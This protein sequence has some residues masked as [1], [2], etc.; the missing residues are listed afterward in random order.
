MFNINDFMK[1]KRIYTTDIKD[2]LK[3]GMVVRIATD[4]ELS[5]DGRVRRTSSWNNSNERTICFL[6]SS[7]TQIQETERPYR[8]FTLSPTAIE[9]IKSNSGMPLRELGPVPDHGSWT[10]ATNEIIVVVEEK[11]S[12]RI[13]HQLIRVEAII[14]KIDIEPV[15]MSSNLEMIERLKALNEKALKGTNSE[16]TV[17]YRILNIKI[18]SKE[19]GFKINPTTRRR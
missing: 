9:Y 2:E 17:E 3:P 19:F 18:P 16:K 5:E 7:E 14:G 11:E 1:Y 15:L 6:T 12:E 8:E 4:K 13:I 10:Q